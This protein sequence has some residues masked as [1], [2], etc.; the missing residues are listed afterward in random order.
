M[1]TNPSD[2]PC[3]PA[4]A[5]L[6]EALSPQRFLSA[7]SRYAGK[8]KA[9]AAPPM[10][11]A[12]HCA[13]I[14]ALYDPGSHVRIAY[15]ISDKPLSVLRSWPA[16]EVFYARYPVRQPMSRR[17]F[18][19]CTEGFDVEV[20]RFPNDRRLRGMRKFNGRDRAAEVW[21]RWL[22]REEPGFKLASDTLRRGLLRYVPEQ[23]WVIHLH[24]Q[25]RGDA[26]ED[27]EKRAVAVRSADVQHC[28][29][30][31]ERLLSLRR[32]RNDFDGAFRILKPVALDTHLGLLVTRWSWGDSLLDML[33]R[34]DP[35]HVMN[36]VA[37]GLGALHRMPIEGLETINTAQ[38]LSA[39]Q[40][41]ARD[42]EAVL[43]S[44]KTA[45]ESL[46]AELSHRC[47]EDDLA[48]YATCHND[49]HW[50]QLRGR[51]ERLTILDVEC[52]ALGDP[53]MDVATFVTQLSMLPRRPELAVETKE[54][55]AW[56]QAFLT[57]W[58]SNRGGAL[59]DD[60]INWYSAIALLVLARGLMR[61]LRRGWPE[62]A[63]QCV[64]SATAAL[65]TSATE[66]AQ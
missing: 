5:G 2:R 10:D 6:F 14:E 38:R 49:F 43:P 30:M 50:N 28:K 15:V 36:H 62:L 18:V 61:H 31:Y 48:H 16:G 53:W 34:H 1:L 55:A 40:D 54:A 51:P 39:A 11:A 21:Q 4:F 63:C 13:V 7:L 3:D 33:R 66:V 64:E 8:P 52:M 60:R 32:V 58:Q 57:A 35:Q 22:E 44:L 24:A 41:C 9:T 17:G 37:A 19:M 47:P 20:Y 29:T 59:D 27:G 12:S 45:L 26:A 25:V 42:L 23:K 65:A 46:L 56:S